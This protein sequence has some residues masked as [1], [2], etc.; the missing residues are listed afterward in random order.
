MVSDT[1]WV[2]LPPLLI[3]SVPFPLPFPCPFEAPFGGPFGPFCLPCP[4]PR[5][6]PWPPCP[7]PCPWPPPYLGDFGCW[8]WSLF[9][10]RGLFPESWLYFW[11]QFDCSLRSPGTKLLSMHSSQGTRHSLQPR[12]EAFEIF[13]QYTHLQGSLDD[14]I[15][16]EIRW[17]S[18]MSFEWWVLRRCRIL[19]S[20]ACVKIT[21]PV[22]C[23]YQERRAL[24]LALRWALLNETLMM[25]NTKKQPEKTR[26]HTLQCPR[27]RSNNTKIQLK[28]ESWGPEIYCIE[29]NWKGEQAVP[30]CNQINGARQIPG[31][32]PAQKQWLK[33]TAEP[34][35]EFI[36]SGTTIQKGLGEGYTSTT[37]DPRHGR[38][39][40][41]GRSGQ[42]ETRG[43]LSPTFIYIYIY[44][45]T[46]I[47]MYIY[48]Y[49][50]S[51]FLPN[52]MISR[53]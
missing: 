39:D 51:A 45:F 6:R 30:E 10:C 31:A 32:H 20:P 36:V 34:T 25:T 28:A 43:G 23:R 13:M 8:D 53:D 33:A 49:F 2:P 26:W 47:Y 11:F 27:R 38:E 35:R 42:G 14:M 1:I 41:S 50:F 7:R 4:W 3:C 18:P 21:R 46:N 9:P 19:R 5:P 15:A 16:L 37:P 40:C 17:M 22:R 52:N 29:L 24:A 12:A 48:I 44:T